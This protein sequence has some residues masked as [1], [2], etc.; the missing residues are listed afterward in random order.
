MTSAEVIPGVDASGERCPRPM[1]V[2]RIDWI[3]A[4]EH[5]LGRDIRAG[6]LIGCGAETGSA[7]AG[8]DCCPLI[9]QRDEIAT[10]HGHSV[11]LRGLEMEAPM[12]L[13][14][15][16]DSSTDEMLTRSV[17]A[18]RNPAGGHQVAAGRK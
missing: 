7:K 13:D 18:I 9:D 14:K 6:E 11:R 1:Q 5:Q 15:G 16:L 8:V 4:V 2:Q 3:I 12:Q 17:L 10:E